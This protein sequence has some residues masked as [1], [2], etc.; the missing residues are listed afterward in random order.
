MGSSSQ[1]QAGIMRRKKSSPAGLRLPPYQVSRL[2]ADT[3][4]NG[5]GIAFAPHNFTPSQWF[6]LPRYF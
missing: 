4:P 5:V 6:P 2:V 3:R 1:D